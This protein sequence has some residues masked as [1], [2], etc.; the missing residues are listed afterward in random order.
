M[1]GVSKTT[2]SVSIQ[3][4]DTG[5]KANVNTKPSNGELGL[6]VIAEI[7]NFQELADAINDPEAYSGPP[8]FRGYNVEKNGTDFSIVVGGTNIFTKSG[9]GR[10]ESIAITFSLGSGCTLEFLVN[11][12]SRWTMTNDL[13]TDMSTAESWNCPFALY[14]AGKTIVWYP[15]FPAYYSTSFQFKA[16]GS[17]KQVDGYIITYTDE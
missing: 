3:D 2:G 9:K 14:N 1:S 15:N 4:Q 16:Y 7:N 12:V 8:A 17:S 10:V 5:D 6:E 11:G 13:L